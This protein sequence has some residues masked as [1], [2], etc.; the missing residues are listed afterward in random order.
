MPK[1]YVVTRVSWFKLLVS[2]DRSA[3][4][5]PTS[6]ER[7]LA[8]GAAT[9][10]FDRT[11]PRTRARAIASANAA[12][13]KWAFSD[14]E[15]RNAGLYLNSACHGEVSCARFHTYGN[16]DSDLLSRVCSP[17]WPATAGS[18]ALGIRRGACCGTIG[19]GQPP[20]VADGTASECRR[21]Q[22]VLVSVVGSN[23]TTGTATECR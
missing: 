6:S 7:W 5:R 21:R 17:R 14:A 20:F 18:H 3:S 15:A 16:R 23:S 22:L 2:S 9:W 13:L 4:P 11:W 19:V 10:K 12:L 1:L 8:R